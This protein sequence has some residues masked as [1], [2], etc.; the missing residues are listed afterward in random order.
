MVAAFWGRSAPGVLDNAAL[1]V[2]A[3][4]ERSAAAACQAKLARFLPPPPDATR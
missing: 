2:P 1:T 4:G 3:G